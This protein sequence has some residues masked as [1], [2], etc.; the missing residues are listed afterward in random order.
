MQRWILHVDMDAFFASVEQ[1]DNE[2][3][4]GK[5]VIVGGI[6][7]R[8]VV[9]TASYEARRFGIRSAMPMAK[10][11]QL[12]PDGIYLPCDHRKY[13]Q[14]A[15]KIRVIMADFSPLIEPLSIDE[16]FLDV[17]GMEMLYSDPAEIALELKA[18]IFQETG[19]TAS[20]GL[21]PNKFLAKL[22][23][24]LK[25]PSGLVVVREGEEKAFLRDLPIKR[26]WGVGPATAGQ[27]ELLGIRTI[28]QLA[29]ADPML[30][31]QQLGQNATDM[32]R[33]ARGID[34]RPVIS[35]H[36]PKSV[37]NEETFAHDI[38][39]RQELLLQLLAL[40]EKVA[41][42]LRQL[43]LSGRTLTLKLRYASFKTLTRSQTLPEPT[44]YDEEIYQ[45]VKLM[46]EKMNLQEGVRL[47][48]VTLSNL[49]TCDGGQISLFAPAPADDK[50]R[51]LHAAVD[52][53]R[54]RYGRGIVTKAPL[55]KNEERD[56]D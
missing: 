11:R 39:D 34:E 22:A 15:K 38:F 21:A 26:M 29:E 18:R 25:K 36:M 4:R 54:N 5:A 20:A 53:L 6:G 49:Q 10:A 51:K 56:N 14:E 40:S 23:S 32:Q 55:C 52:D 48:G 8:G 41:W 43:R 1:R 35:E 28:G 12:C 16:A 2:E 31:L 13:M 47:L 24:D 9:S 33:L 19:L 46:L 37:G 17:S 30:L 7:S 44:C 27:L 42:R 3:Y 50:K 45:A